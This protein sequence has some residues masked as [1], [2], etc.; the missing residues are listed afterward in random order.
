MKESDLI[1]RI[2]IQTLAYIAVNRM[3]IFEVDG[4]YY[5]QN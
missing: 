3:A 5:L 2:N 1:I 4:Q